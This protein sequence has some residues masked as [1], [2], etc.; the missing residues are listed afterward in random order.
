MESDDKDDGAVENGAGSIP[1]DVIND[2]IA[3]LNAAEEEGSDDENPVV[4]STDGKE[5]EDD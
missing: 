4:S 2:M 3:E 5:K 1:A